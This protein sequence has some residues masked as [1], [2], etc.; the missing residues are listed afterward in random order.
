VRHGIATARFAARLAMTTRRLEAVNAIDQLEQTLRAANAAAL[1][2]LDVRDTALIEDELPRLQQWASAGADLEEVDDE[3]VAAAV[4][5]Y[6]ETGNLEGI[7][8]ARAVCYGCIREIDGV[9][10]I[11]EPQRIKA[12]IEYV[13]G[14]RY[15]PRPFRRCYRALLHAYFAYDPET[16]L[17]EGGRKGWQELWVFLERRKNMLETP[18]SDPGWVTALLEHRN[19]LTR[20]PTSRYGMGAL[21]GNSGA[22]D[23]VRAR[24]GI[25]EDSWV[26]RRLV[27]SMLQ[28]AIQLTDQHFKDS[29]V[30]LLVLFS[31]HPLLLD[32]GLARV[33]DRYA[34]SKTTE[35]HARLREFV[36]LNWGDP[37][38]VANLPHWTGV[39]RKAR[40][41]VAGWLNSAESKVD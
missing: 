30:R 18:G 32:Y 14:F 2:G 20:D 28:A 33:I 36:V 24:L 13:D 27:L 10:L 26:V 38:V 21:R 11:E 8:H 39:E 19:L 12:L 22:F 34:A 17:S 16:E 7:G 37:R 1:E 31:K 4:R 35:V 29:V 41:M 5:I 9:R 40:E 25:A 6:R 3:T 15:L 23:A